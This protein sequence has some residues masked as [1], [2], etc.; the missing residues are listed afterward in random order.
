MPHQQIAIIRSAE[1]HWLAHWT[2]NGERFYPI[3]MKNIMPKNRKAEDLKRY[4]EV[5][6]NIL[7]GAWTIVEGS[8]NR[9]TRILTVYA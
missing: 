6:N 7:S 9:A 4:S 3:N 1:T 2:V 8:Y 5:K